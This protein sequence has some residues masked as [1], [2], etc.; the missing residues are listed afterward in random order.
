MAKVVKM[1]ENRNFRMPD[2]KSPKMVK[3]SPQRP[4][5]DSKMVQIEPQRA[6]TTPTRTLRTLQ[7]P[8][9]R[10]PDAP[11]ALQVS[12]G[13]DFGSPGDSAEPS[14]S[15]RFLKEINGFR[16]W[17]QRGPN[18]PPDPAPDPEEGPH[19]AKFAQ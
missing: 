7:G 3:I 1:M 15:F 6:P 13:S 16:V 8:P 4:P 14:K 10:Q 19:G 5:G 12:L 17:T 9:R 2:L 11:E 18:T